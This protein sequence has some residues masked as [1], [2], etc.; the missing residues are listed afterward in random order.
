MKKNVIVLYC[1]EDTVKVID[2]TEKGTP[3]SF[4]NADMMK[5]LQCENAFIHYHSSTNVYNS[6]QICIKNKVLSAKK[7]N[8]DLSKNGFERFIQRA[9]QAFPKHQYEYTLVFQSHCW[10]NSMITYKSTNKKKHITFLTTPEMVSIVAD[11]MERVKSVIFDC[12]YMS[13]LENAQL[14]SKVTDYM[15]ACESASPN[16]G[17]ISCAKNLPKY[18][19]MPPEKGFKRIADDCIRYNSNPKNK[20]IYPTDAAILYLPALRT[21]NEQ[22]EISKLE[23]QNN[24]YSMKIF[25]LYNSLDH[26][27]DID[28]LVK[29]HVYTPTANKKDMKGIAISTKD[30]LDNDM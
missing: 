3:C 14:V 5:L 1:V 11:V 7:I 23:R 24:I 26:K 13:T 20:L 9:V 30:T 15:L 22:F 28:K 25:D 16:F 18:I 12:C 4:R 27:V 10:I 21:L 6:L 19:E 17:F 2:S 8:H 29:Y